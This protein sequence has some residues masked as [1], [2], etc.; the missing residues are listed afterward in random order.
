VL[1]SLL[2]HHYL[3]FLLP[4][5][6]FFFNLPVNLILL[7]LNLLQKNLLLLNELLALLVPY[8]CRNRHLF[9]QLLRP[10]VEQLL[11]VVISEVRPVRHLV[12]RGVATAF[13]EYFTGE[14]VE[15]C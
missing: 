6:L 10:V 15:D 13:M 11:D 2:L 7:H 3:I 9:N 4:F 5:N 12:S 14:W 1:D 8:L